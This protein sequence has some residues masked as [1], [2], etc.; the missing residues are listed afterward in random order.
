MIHVI[1]FKKS[2]S[3]ELGAQLQVN[4]SFHLSQRGTT[5]LCI[6]QYKILCGPLQPECVFSEQPCGYQFSLHVRVFVL[7]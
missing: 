2:F 1:I 5:K 7:R 4:P 6:R 3:A